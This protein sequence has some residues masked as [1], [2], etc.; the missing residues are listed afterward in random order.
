MEGGETYI[1][2]DLNIF[3]GTMA[4]S[5]KYFSQVT[6]T[7]VMTPV[8]TNDYIKGH[9]NGLFTRG[10]TDDDNGLVVPHFVFPPIA[11]RVRRT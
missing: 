11:E 6:N 4:L 9:K 5:P 7:I 3:K 2:P 8:N 10:G 1:E